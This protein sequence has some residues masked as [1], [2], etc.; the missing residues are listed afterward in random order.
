[1]REEKVEAGLVIGGCNQ[2]VK[3][4]LFYILQESEFEPGFAKLIKMDQ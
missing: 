3:D 2:R 4:G 1:M